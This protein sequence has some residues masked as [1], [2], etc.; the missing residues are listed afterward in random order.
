MIHKTVFIASGAK[1]IGDVSCGENSSIW[2]N[3]VVRGDRQKIIIGKFSNIQDNCV[4]H[5]EKHDAVLG[6]YVSIG[7]A[8]ES[9]ISILSGNLNKEEEQRITSLLEKLGLPTKIE[10]NTDTKKI[11]DFMIADKKTRNQKP[12]FVILKEI[13][14][15]KTEN[16]NFSFEIK[17]DI[18]KKAIEESK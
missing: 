10:K 6:N 1:I 15:T 3:T 11:L 18:T 9:K 12:R 13:G 16:N 14:K 4:V 8:V 5:A 17:E 2:Y 7:I